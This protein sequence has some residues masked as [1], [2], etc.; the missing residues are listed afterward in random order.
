MHDQYGVRKARER[1]ADAALMK[2]G[3]VKEAAGWDTVKRVVSAPFRFHPLQS[4]PTTLG[5]KVWH[6][7]AHVLDMGRHLVF[8]SPI[9]DWERFQH[10]RQQSGSGL[11]AYGQMAKDYMW[12]PKTPFESG[13][14]KWFRRG[15]NTLGLA[16]TG[17]EAYRALTGDPS[18]RAGDIAALGTSLVAGP[19]TGSLGMFAGPM[20][21]SALTSTARSAGHLLDSPTQQPLELPP[22]RDVPEHVSRALRSYNTIKDQTGADPR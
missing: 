13:G 7:A 8:G 16:M 21:H 5:E 17:A 1:G 19:V 2:L 4:T 10:L 11:K 20:V 15:M 14:G 12:S 6:G 3:F 18:Q 9:N 22:S